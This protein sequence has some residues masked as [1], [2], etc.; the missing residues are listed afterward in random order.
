MVL[1]KQE[2]VEIKHKKFLQW[3]R[4][5]YTAIVFIF[6]V[7]MV[8]LGKAL[9]DA[10]KPDVDHGNYPIHAVFSYSNGYLSITNKDVFDW[11]Y[12]WFYLDTD[13]DA[14]TYEYY[15]ESDEIASGTTFTLDLRILHSNNG[16]TYFDPATI[17]PR[18]LSLFARTSKGTGHVIYKFK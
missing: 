11:T 18:H 12:P 2:K 4:L 9:Y 16:L 7:G 17:T 3:Q 6:C 5:G 14:A 1:K 15:N 10:G 8:L 13:S